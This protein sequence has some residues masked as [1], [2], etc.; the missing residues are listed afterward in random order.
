MQS[1]WQGRILAAGDTYLGPIRYSGVI[2]GKGG[3]D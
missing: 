2:E 3:K 1:L